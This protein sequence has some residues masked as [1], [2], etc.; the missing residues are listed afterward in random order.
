MALGFLVAHF[1]GLGPQAVRF[2]VDA[3]RRSHPGKP[4]DF[5]AATYLR[6][7]V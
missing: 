7:L 5:G 6:R 1:S 2:Y 4:P 3:Q